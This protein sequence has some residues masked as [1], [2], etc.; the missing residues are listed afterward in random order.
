MRKV[1]VTG[2]VAKNVHELPGGNY[3]LDPLQ[4]AILRAK[5]PHLEA[6]LAKR[7]RHAEMLRQGLAGTSPSLVVPTD[8]VHGRH[9]YAQFTVRHPQ[10]D[11]LQR[12]LRARDVASEV[13]Y[14]IPMPY[15]KVFASLGHRDG[16]FPHA[17]RACREVLSIPVHSELTDTDVA[18][19]VEATRDAVREI[20]SRA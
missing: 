14:P 6:R 2:A 20:E 5:L 4:A 9:V 10:R 16:E 13:Y 3:R 12:A 8:D 19:V 18:R 15:Q 11:D 17:E 7:R 1:R